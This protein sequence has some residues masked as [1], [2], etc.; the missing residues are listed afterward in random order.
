MIRQ[1]LNDL[2]S[3]SSFIIVDV[4][5]AD[6]HQEGVDL[7]RSFDS[8]GMVRTLQSPLIFASPLWI[9][10]VSLVWQLLDILVRGDLAG[11]S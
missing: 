8:R 9:G 3:G 6:L 2:Y 5:D 4:L 10:P 1:L 11:A 7:H